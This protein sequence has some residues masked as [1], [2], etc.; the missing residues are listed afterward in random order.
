MFSLRD[1]WKSIESCGTSEILWRKES[2]VILEISCPSIKIFP[3]LISKNLNNNFTSVD[4][5][6]QLSQTNAIFSQA[7]IFKLKSFKNQTHS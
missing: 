6:D 7:F 3:D 1:L 4:F 2:C 5:Q